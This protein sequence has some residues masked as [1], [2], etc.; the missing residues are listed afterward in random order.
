MSTQ[1]AARLEII[2]HIIP[3]SRVILSD[4]DWE[5]YEDLIKRLGDYSHLRV[6]YSDGR[7]EVMSP[8]TPH[9]KYK[10]LINAL[11]RSIGYEL[12][13]DVMSFGSFTMKI[14]R[15]HKGAEADDSFYIQHASTMIG[16]DQ[17]ELGVDPPPDLV[18]EIDMTRDSRKKFEI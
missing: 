14:D 7:L 16:K 5:E 1:T 17:L 4:V 13:I 9:E 2:G 3:G 12:E 10:S 18:I 8:S 15:L 11:V 6:S